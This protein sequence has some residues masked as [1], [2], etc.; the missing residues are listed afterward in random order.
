MEKQTTAIKPIDIF[1]AGTHTAMSGATL[2]FSDADLMAIA[3]N[4]QAE[5]DP[6]PIVV[7]HPQTNDPAYGWV[8][9]LEYAD[10]KLTATPKQVEPQFAEMVQAGRFKKVSAS[11][12][13]PD[14]PANPHPGQYYIRHVGFLG[15]AA[16]AV[17]GLKNAQFADSAAGFVDF[18]LDFTV[19]DGWSMMSV[20]KLFRRVR[21]YLIS[22]KD[23]A[24]ADSVLPEYEIA[25]LENGATLAIAAGAGALN[26][27]LTMQGFS[28]HFTNPSKDDPMTP[29]EKALLDAAQT[30][31]AALK[32]QLAAKDV[33][34]A[35]AQNQTRQAAAHA[36]H[37]G[38]AENL[39]QAAQLLP[40]NQLT[41]VAVLDALA[42]PAANISFGEGDA[43]V[44]LLDAFK[45]TLSAAPKHLS[46]GELGADEKG[47]AKAV[48]FNAPHG[49][50]VDADDLALA[51]KAE[52]YAAKNKCSFVDAL[53]AVDQ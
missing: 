32:A 11:F 30:E 49:Y 5:T 42:V 3:Q 21:E 18:T 4:Y 51:Q 13:M 41:V 7:G 2:S 24:T 12:Y 36:E 50:A 26:P 44:P 47:A 10:G 25:S 20:A 8:A 9:S 48:D 35:E 1:K 39:V 34:F 33:A 43:A 29:E 38:F 22:D 46:F 15:A 40:V 31:N 6:A 27:D 14:S 37:V 52:A 53:R 23:M 17:K 28:Q 45:A 19:Q 16:P